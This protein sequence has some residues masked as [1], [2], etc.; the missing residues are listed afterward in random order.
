MTDF[1][2]RMRLAFANR[3]DLV[4]GKNCPVRMVA[5]VDGADIIGGRGI[6][7]LGETE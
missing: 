6:A 1:I 2:F 4:L 3:I 7:A 5:P